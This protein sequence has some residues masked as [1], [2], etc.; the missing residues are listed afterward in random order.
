MLA[1]DGRVARLA[2]FVDRANRERR[3]PGRVGENRAIR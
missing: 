2:A 1:C 3:R